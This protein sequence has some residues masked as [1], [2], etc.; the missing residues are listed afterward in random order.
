MHS[1]LQSLPVSWDLLYLNGCFKK[2]GPDVATGVK[3]A[4][5]GLC[6]YGYV[7]SQKGVSK[8]LTSTSLIKSDKPIDH[9]LDTEI[10]RGKLLAFHAKPPLISIMYEMK[11]TMAY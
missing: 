10:S 3:L 1:L 9:V 2:F 4:R 5:G 11:S 6:T 7:I 8:L